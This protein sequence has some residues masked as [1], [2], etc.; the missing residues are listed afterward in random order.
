[1]TS[2]AN[3]ARN[4]SDKIDPAPARA[5]L[6]LST[7]KFTEAVNIFWEIS[8]AVHNNAK[9]ASAYLIP[10]SLML[11]PGGGG[12]GMDADDPE[13]FRRGSPWTPAFHRAHDPVLK[14]RMSRY[15]ERGAQMFYLIIRKEALS[16]SQTNPAVKEVVSMIKRFHRVASAYSVFFHWNRQEAS[17]LWI[18]EVDLCTMYRG[19]NSPSALL[20]VGE[21]APVGWVKRDATRT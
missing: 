16:E 8:Q 1:M 14:P 13:R 7:V 3:G 15:V 5:S 11:S 21:D 2:E 20:Q 18:V 17:D 9:V 10:S 19:I 6:R 12:G 4:H